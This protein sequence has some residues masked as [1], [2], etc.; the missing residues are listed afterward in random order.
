MISLTSSTLT[1]HAEVF[2]FVDRGFKV[3]LDY[4]VLLEHDLGSTVY[5]A[6]HNQSELT[7]HLPRSN[8]TSFTVWVLN[9]SFLPL[10]V[11]VKRKDNQT[12]FLGTILWK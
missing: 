7:L 3:M 5:N 9:S 11:D 2:T 10:V 6:P 8:S 4:S 1:I 12:P